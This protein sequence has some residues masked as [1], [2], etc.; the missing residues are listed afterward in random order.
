MPEIAH[1]AHCSAPVAIA[2]ARSSRD[3]RGPT[4]DESSVPKKYTTTAVSASGTSSDAICVDAFLASVACF[5]CSS[6]WPSS[7]APITIAT[8]REM[9]GSAEMNTTTFRTRP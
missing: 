8:T 4:S 1:G 2:Q 9:P 7:S 6:A 3:A 5:R